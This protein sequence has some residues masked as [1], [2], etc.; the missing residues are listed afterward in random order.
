MLL[1]A[2]QENKR[3]SESDDETIAFLFGQSCYSDAYRL[4]KNEPSNNVVTQYNLALC[5]YWIGNYQEA[6]T[7]L[8]KAMV[9]LPA[10]Q[11]KT[12]FGIDNFYE[13]MLEKQNQSDDH[14]L[15]I[16]QKIVSLMLDKVAD[17]IT[18]LKTDCWLNLENYAKVIEVA[19]PLA[20]KNY[21]NITYALAIAKRNS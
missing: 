10:H 20:F 19:T 13:A 5:F 4:L 1:G 16:T 17:G 9:Y 2:T 21:R 6:L 3:N 12:N 11:S 18:R 14:H 7:S 15:A 8:D